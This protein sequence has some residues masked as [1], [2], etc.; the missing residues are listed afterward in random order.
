MKSKSVNTD[1]KL[2]VPQVGR[3]FNVTDDQVRR[4]IRRGVVRAVRVGPLGAWRMSEA[5]I[6]SA[7]VTNK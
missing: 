5:D 2:T 6:E 7:L 1:Y 4:W 3:K